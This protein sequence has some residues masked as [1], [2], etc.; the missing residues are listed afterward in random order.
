MD[1]LLARVCI[2]YDTK[3][4]AE[5]EFTKCVD[6]SKRIAAQLKL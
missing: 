4:V 1:D 2:V 3:L 5:G 6:F